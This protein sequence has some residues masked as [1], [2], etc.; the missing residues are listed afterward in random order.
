LP[1]GLIIADV[2]G[3]KLINDALGHLE[4]DKILIRAAEIL[5]KSCRQKDIISRWGGDE[6]IILMPQ[7]DRATA[8]RIF[9]RIKNSFISI[10]SLSILIN[11]SLGLAIQ[12]HLDR[13]IRNVIK[14]A[15]EKMYRHKLLESRSTRSSFIKS[16]EKTLWGRSH[17]TEE[18]CQ[19]M[20][21]MAEKMGRTFKLTESELDNLKLLATLH[22]IGKIAIPSSILDK[23]EKLSPD[24]WETIKNH[25]E[26][27]YRIAISSPELAPIAEGILHHHECW[28]GSGYP[29]G[30]RGEKIPLISRI[31]A[32]A[33]AY[34]VMINGRPYKEAISEEEALAE[35]E[36]CAGT[37]FDPELVRKVVSFERAEMRRS[38]F[39]MF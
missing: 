32:I 13:D 38:S 27:G 36:R 4:G 17:E 37:Q 26:I 28:D 29:L 7:C 21:E 16:L 5:R 22:D 19:R 39:M 6:F 1:L 31:I 8:L 34:D 11:I 30:L 18:H 24:E 12:Y 3:L 2:N 9:R 23:S 20:Q 35:I 10:D 15:E 25:P 14:E 33:D